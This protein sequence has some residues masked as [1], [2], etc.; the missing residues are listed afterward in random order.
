M[1]GR[2]GVGRLGRRPKL[3]PK[4]GAARVVPPA[5]V[6]SEELKAYISKWRKSTGS[7]SSL[8][9][10]GPAWAVEVQSASDARPS[11]KVAVQAALWRDSTRFTPEQCLASAHACSNLRILE[12]GGPW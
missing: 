10:G 9:K 8:W 1:A 12:R 5:A 11:A 4:P 7:G 6:P 2:G 3:P